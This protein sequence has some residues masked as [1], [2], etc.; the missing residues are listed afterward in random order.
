MKTTT[1]HTASQAKDESCLLRSLR[2]CCCC[3]PQTEQTVIR[4]AACVPPLTC[5]GKGGKG[6]EWCVVCEWSA[7]KIEK[8]EN[9][10]QASLVMMH[11]GIEQA[12]KPTSSPPLGMHL[13]L[14]CNRK[15]DPWSLDSC[16]GQYCP[17]LLVHHC[18][19][20]H[21]HHPRTPLIIMRAHHS[22]VALHPP[23]LPPLHPQ[24]LP[25]HNTR[26]LYS[27]HPRTRRPPSRFSS[28]FLHQETRDEDQQR[29]KQQRRAC[30]AW[31]PGTATD[32]L[33]EHQWTTIT[34]KHKLPTTNTRDRE[35]LA[36]LPRPSR[37]VS[38]RAPPFLLLRLLLLLLL[39]LLFHHRRGT[40]PPP[41]HSSRR[42]QRTKSSRHTSTLLLLL[43]LLLFLPPPH[44]PPAT[45]GPLAFLPP[46]LPS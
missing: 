23:A 1:D 19:A 38:I 25:T 10:S 16:D 17:Q 26:G 21:H 29:D 33:S 42:Q 41:Q 30:R 6:F 43:L 20:S 5:Q 4:P 22:H 13:L 45:L 24:P 12:S 9:E 28:S 44:Q 32:E 46:A 2:T 37:A 35:C 7:R 39:L 11:V 8:E 31:A 40:P 14:M 34:A 36:L 3:L 18:F 27:L 15:L